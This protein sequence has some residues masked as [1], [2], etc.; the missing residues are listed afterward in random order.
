MPDGSSSAAPVTS[1]GPSRLRTSRH[2]C[3]TGDFELARCTVS[4]VERA[5][6]AP[7]RRCLSEQTLFVGDGSAIV[8]LAH[9]AD[10]ATTGAC[11]L[12]RSRRGHHPPVG[13]EGGDCG[14]FFAK[15]ARQ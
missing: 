3:L 4:S 6:P 11:C 13:G 8:G 5:A 2:L 7:P 9:H 1:P 15:L 10:R 12:V 14:T